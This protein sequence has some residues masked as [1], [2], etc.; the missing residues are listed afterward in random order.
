MVK[1]KWK[2]LTEL[3]C[4]FTSV[5]HSLMSLNR[6]RTP[7]TTI[8]IATSLAIHPGEAEAEWMTVTLAFTRGSASVT[9]AYSLRRHKGTLMPWKHS[10]LQTHRVHYIW[11]PVCKS[12]SS[13]EC[14]TYKQGL[15][16]RGLVLLIKTVSKGTLRQKLLFLLCLHTSSEHISTKERRGLKSYQ[17]LKSQH[18]GFSVNIH[19]SIRNQTNCHTLAG[20]M[21]WDISERQLDRCSSILSREGV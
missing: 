8:A 18:E 3:P 5:L 14:I 12:Q 6:G 10:K 17:T 7:T 19:N 9:M 21:E 1:S 2:C 13:S 15:I 20:R 11:L 16:W 4:S